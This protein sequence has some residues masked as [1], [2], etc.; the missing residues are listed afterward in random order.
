VTT[1]LAL[2]ARAPRATLEYVPGARYPVTDETAL[3]VLVRKWRINPGPAYVDPD[4]EA[5]V[6]AS[7][8]IGAAAQYLREVNRTTAVIGTTV[9]ELAR[10]GRQLSEFGHRDP[11]A[12]APEYRVP[13]SFGRLQAAELNVE[14][15]IVEY[16]A[17][18]PVCEHRKVPCATCRASLLG[19][20]ARIAAR[21]EAFTELETQIARLLFRRSGVVLD[22]EQIYE[23]LHVAL[24]GRPG[25]GV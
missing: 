19:R 17:A 16:R 12:P 15:L 21:V 2:G 22:V 3:A 9:A 18:L 1:T 14:E 13:V 25:V 23:V 7:V 11:N 5:H 6:I 24:G 4:H 10:I 20:A 8:L